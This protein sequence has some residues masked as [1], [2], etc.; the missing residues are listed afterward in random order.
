MERSLKDRGFIAER[1][2]KNVISPFAEMLE[3]R[4]WQSLGEH[5]EPGYASLVKEF[6][7]NMVEKEGK[8]VYVRG[9]WVEFSR[10]EINRLFSLRV[11]N[12]GSKFKKQL[13]EQEH[14]KI[15]DLLTPGKGKWKGT[16]KTPFKS[17]ARGDLT[18]EAKVWF[19][20]ISYVLMPSK[21]L[22]T[23]R[24]EEAILLYTLL[25]GYKINVAKMIEKSIL[26]YSESKGRGMIPHPSTIT[27]L[28]IQ[29]GVEEE[30]GTEE[31]Y[32]RASPLTLTGITKGLANRGKG[33]EKETEE[34]K[35]NEGC[36]EL[37]QWESQTPMQ[38]E[39]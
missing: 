29:G 5:K 2:F 35:G 4:G 1:G 3:K 22:S 11:Q 19:Y 30:W 39:A 12:D 37:E 17:I 27:R 33:K 26:G 31:T 9:H 10:E 28:C 8:I 38:P 13:K 32:P 34:E 15:V 25:K 21:H 20:F 23:V 24:R 6:F 14:Q 18:K 36:T 7:A 16:K